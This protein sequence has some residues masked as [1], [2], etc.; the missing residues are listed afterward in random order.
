MFRAPFDGFHAATRPAYVD[1]LLS[2][3]SL[4]RTGYF[5]AKAVTYWRQA[6][7]GLRAGSNQRTSIEM[8]LVAVLSTQLWHNHFIDGSLAD[9]PSL[10]AKTSRL[11]PA[12]I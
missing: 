2:Q 11:S 4:L 6:Y 5:D 7:R 8:G 10:S 3:E 12:P 1:Q 9:L